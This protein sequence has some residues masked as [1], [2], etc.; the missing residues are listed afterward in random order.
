MLYCSIQRITVLII[1]ILLFFY[2]E[3]MELFKSCQL[4]LKTPE[5]C[6]KTRHSM[7]DIQNVQRDFELLKLCNVLQ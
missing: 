7:L 3:N 4:N 2:Q 5:L 1:Y 6:C